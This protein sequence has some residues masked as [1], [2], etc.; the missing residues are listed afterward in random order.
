MTARIIDP[1]RQTSGAATTV[2]PF[3]TR[4]KRRLYGFR[5]SASGATAVEF[6]MVMPLFMLVFV[7][8]LQC[9]LYIFCYA[10]VEKATADAS[11]AVMLGALTQDASTANGFRKTVFCT[12]LIAGLS[13]DRIITSLQTTTL[14]GSG[15]GFAAFINPEETGLVPVVMDKDRTPYCPGAPGTYGYIQVFYPVPVFSFLWLGLNLGTDSTFGKV[16]YARAAIAFRNE[17]FT[18]RNVQVPC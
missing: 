18:T 5:R 2:L 17:P 15:G 4:C 9:G 3:A 16:S 6:A 1:D 8:I 14:T 10:A 11:R 13:C 7:E 12:K